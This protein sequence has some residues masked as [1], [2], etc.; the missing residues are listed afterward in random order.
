MH[1][2][3]RQAA[4]KYGL[5][6]RKNGM[7]CC[8]FHRDK[9]PSMKIDKNYHCFACGIGGDAIDYVSRMF[10]L[11]QYQAAKKLIDDFSLMVEHGRK[12]ALS[13]KEKEKIIRARQENERIIRIK[14][15]FGR[16]CSESIGLLRNCIDEIRQAG[17]LLTDKAQ[18]QIFTDD[19]TSMLNAEPIMEYWLD[20][21]CMGTEKDR[22]ELFLLGR[23][24][25]DRLAETVGKSYRRIVECNRRSA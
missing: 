6:I 3:A 1:L 25:V 24:G 23:K 11:T 14:K 21:L 9:H 22:Q 4:E 17:I 2:T 18:N 13:A 7:V 15:R 10:G 16:W 5:A 8:P 12:M 20:I 19:Y